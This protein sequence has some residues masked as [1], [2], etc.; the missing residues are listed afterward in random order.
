MAGVSA[1]AQCPFQFRYKRCNALHQ[2]IKV[3]LRRG[4]SF[5]AP[6]REPSPEQREVVDLAIPVKEMHPDVLLRHRS[7]GMFDPCS[8]RDTDVQS[9]RRASVSVELDFDHLVPAHRFTAQA[10][11]R[12][13]G[14]NFSSLSVMPIQ[15]H[16][17]KSAMQER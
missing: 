9:K 12:K 14:A 3:R 1:A 15:R 7:C 8:W 2:R 11:E 16:E 4:A 17:M 13:Y 6:Q 10:A 5:P